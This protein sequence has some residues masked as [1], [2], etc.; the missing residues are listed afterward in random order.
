MQTQNC[1]MLVTYLCISQYYTSHHR[2]HDDEGINFHHLMALHDV[3]LHGNLFASNAAY[4]VLQ[5]MTAESL[6][7]RLTGYGVTVSALHP[8]IVSV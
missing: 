1:L 4:C 3:F 7:R 8:G 5:V 2:N 6:Q